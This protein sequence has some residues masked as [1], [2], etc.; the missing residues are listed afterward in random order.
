MSFIDRLSGQSLGRPPERAHFGRWLCRPGNRPEHING[1]L[2]CRRRRSGPGSYRRL[3]VR[4]AQSG[5]IPI[6]GRFVADA[7]PDD[8]DAEA[9]L[10]LGQMLREPDG[11]KGGWRKWKEISPFAP[12]LDEEIKPDPLEDRIEVEFKHLAAVC[13]NPR[14]HIR[15]ETERVFVARARLIARD[16]H[17][18]ARLPY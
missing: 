1:C 13:R 2:A 8:Q 3:G 4:S 14:T 18:V 6:R 5:V 15:R 7:V 12:G 11:A 17:G 16:A 10:Q 9:L